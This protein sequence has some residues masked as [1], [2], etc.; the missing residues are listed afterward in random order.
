MS[1]DENQTGAL[2][3][4][5]REAKRLRDTPHWHPAACAFHVI[6]SGLR[7]RMVLEGLELKNHDSDWWGYVGESRTQLYGCCAVQ[8]DGPTFGAV[9]DL[10]VVPELRRLRIGRALLNY[11]ISRQWRRGGNFLQAYVPKSAVPLFVGCGFDVIN[12]SKHDTLCQLSK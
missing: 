10:Y 11:A 3:R 1:S 5:N 9:H 2:L 12:R 8:D 4:K 6:G 7:D